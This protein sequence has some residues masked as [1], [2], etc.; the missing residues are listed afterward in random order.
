MI[1]LYFP[2][3]NS[4]IQITD[5]IL[6]YNGTLAIDGKLIPGV[7]DL[8]MLLSSKLTI[9]IITADTFGTVQQQITE[10][11]CCLTI[12]PP[13]NQ[14]GEK[15]KYL[16]SIGS[17]HT[18]CIGNGKNDNLMLKEAVI[19]IALIQREGAA[20]ESLINAN[21]VCTNIVDALELIINPLRL[22]ATLRL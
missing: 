20:I 22:I 1:E 21:I 17:D 12:L 13:E 11:P 15:L 9:H 4:S 19:G 6:D 7:K 2:G 10:I 16:Q 5:L 3:H 14:T 8:L 18:I